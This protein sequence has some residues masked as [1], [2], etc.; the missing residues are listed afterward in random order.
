M[1][2]VLVGWHLF[3]SAAFGQ[4]TTVRNIPP[5]PNIGNNQSIG[6][7]TQ[8]NLAAGGSIGNFFTAGTPTGSSNIELN[9]A[10]GSVGFGAIVYRTT[11]NI[12]GGAIHNMFTAYDSD[13]NISGGSAGDD[14]M[15]IVGS[16]VSISGGS[17][18]D[19]AI[20]EGTVSIS[21]GSFGRNFMAG[22]G[23]V[24]ISGGT[25]SDSFSVSGTA[26]IFGGEFRSDGVLISG[27]NAVGDSVFYLQPGADSLTGTL[28]DGSLF[29]FADTDSLRDGPVTLHRAALPPVGP[30]MITAPSDLVPT[31]IRGGQTLVVEDGGIVSRNFTAG[32]GSTVKVTGGEVGDNFEAAGATVYIEDGSVGLAMDALPG[33]NVFISGGSVGDG[34]H[35]YAGSKVT[36]AGGSIGIATQVFDG[37]TVVISGG[38]VGGGFNAEPGSHIS[39][40]GGAIGEEFSA[41]EG[42]IVR[43]AGTQFVLDGVDI[44]GSLA[45]NV[46]LTITQRDVTLAGVL[47]DGS[48]FSFDLDSVQE[49]F[50]GFFDPHA[51]L[52]ITRVIPGDFNADANVDAADYVVWRRGLGTMYSPAHYDIWRANFG[53]TAGGGGVAAQSAVVPEPAT[54]VLLMVTLGAGCVR[55]CPAALV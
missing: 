18:G 8:V 46:P 27:L 34:L 44:S 25:F 31:G 33:S 19:D 35:I 50:L 55:R 14:F 11:V 54:L 40:S 6:S 32:F 26:T 20:V 45:V 1:L 49:G 16:T 30:A 51:V 10:G 39:I 36:I 48:P 4:F 3:A 38:S 9:V 21:G 43:L 37:A 41:E 28:A 29:A 17:V 15:A 42:S 23:T 47:A 5:E 22:G 13:I 12:S 53:I 2:L 7:N 52:S 24:T